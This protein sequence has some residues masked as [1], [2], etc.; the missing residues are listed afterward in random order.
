MFRIVRYA[1]SAVCAGVLALGAWSAI[2]APEEIKLEGEIE[3]AEP[4]SARAGAEAN[5]IRG[6]YH[7]A[8][9]L[10]GFEAQGLRAGKRLDTDAVPK[11]V[12]VRLEVNDAVLD[13]EFDYQA[14]IVTLDGHGVMLSPE[15]VMALRGF[16]GLLEKTLSERGL[17]GES[18]APVDVEGRPMGNTA[19]ALHRVATLYSEAPAGF[20]VNRREV[21]E[22][23]DAADASATATGQTLGTEPI[24]QG[25]SRCNQSGG[26][27]N[28]RY[29]NSICWR[30]DFYAWTHH[31]ARSH[32]M[33][34]EW[35]NL[36]CRHPECRG[37]CGATCGSRGGFGNYSKDCLDHD[38]CL[39]IHGGVAWNG[40]NPDCGDEFGD[41][42]DDT[43]WGGVV[44]S[45]NCYPL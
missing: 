42:I 44:C 10:V 41:A 43:V 15:H 30:Y 37:R 34:G 11:K 40:T 3:F 6:W 19:D 23:K 21:R 14:R 31:D 26:D 7:H 17:I 5:E 16:Y 25:A 8:G 18:V 20:I 32:C 36:G 12:I 4:I 28:F 22:G 27:G 1:S 33:L 9:S 39:T 24:G 45:D 2:A 13:H 29:D 38:Y 35:V